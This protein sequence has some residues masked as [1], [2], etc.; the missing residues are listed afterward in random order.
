MLSRT[1]LQTTRSSALRCTPPRAPAFAVAKAAFSSTAIASKASSP[2]A[3]LQGAPPDPILGV[4]EAFK[5]DTDSR[6]INLGVGA[7]RDE[8]GKPFVL[9][10]VRQVSRHNRIST[11]M[12]SANVVC[13]IVS[14][15]PRQMSFKPR[16]TRNTF[17]SPV[18]AT[19][20]RTQPLSHTARTLRRSRRT[21]LQ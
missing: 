12:D 21:E 16:E 7:Y 13:S 4:T 17:P 1:L 19:L 10:S 18:L 9:P 8:N 6:K 5:K 3:S 15:R 11:I 2:F 20:P 14:L